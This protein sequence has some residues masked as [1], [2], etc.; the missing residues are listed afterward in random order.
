MAD[1]ASFLSSTSSNAHWQRIGFRRRAGVCVPLF[2]LYSRQ[3]IGIGDLQ[4]LK[5]FVDWCVATGHT[6][7]QL[8]PLN[9][10]GFN[11]RPYDAQSSCALDPIYLS[12]RNLIGVSSPYTQE[13]KTLAQQY[14][15][16][17]GRVNYALKRDKLACCMTMFEH[18]ERHSIRFKQFKGRTAYWLDD[19]ALFTV[20]KSL[21]N[22]KGWF[23]WDDGFKQRTMSVLNEVKTKHSELLEF[24]RWLQWQLYEQCVEVHSY[25]RA[26]GVLLMGDIPFLT[27]RDSADVWAHP[28]YFRLEQ[29]SGATPDFYCAQGQRWGMPPYNWDTIAHDEYT[30]FKQKLQ[31]NEELY[32]MFR[33]DHLFGV[34]RLWSIPIAEPS[35]TVGLN[36]HFEPSDEHAWETHG[37]TILQM[38]LGSTTMLPCGEDL[39]AAP[40]PAARVMEELGIIGLDVQRWLKDRDHYPYRCKSREEFRTLACAVVSVHDSS[41]A[42]ALWE[43]ELDTVAEG[44]FIKACADAGIDAHAL[45]DILFEPGAAIQGRLRWRKEICTTEVLA[46]KVGKN[47]NELY[48]LVSLYKESFG[49]KQQLWEL[50][51]MTG[52]VEEHVSPA[53]IMRMLEFS[54][55]TN[56]IFS[57]QLL[58]DWILIERYKTIKDIG[59]FRINVPGTVND[60]NWSI[61]LPLSL[62]AM[63]NMKINS[64]ILEMNIKAD[65]A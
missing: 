50:F 13:L 58:L 39:G 10:T 40:P 43:Y 31:Y 27:S 23:E 35:E 14:P 19:Y 63:M 55:H 60:S 12:L 62:E 41:N 47:E 26:K 22:E 37:R 20:I 44:F 15:T 33:I 6:I 45:R 54:A 56:A 18:A 38:M 24:Q 8:L 53:L 21:H 11:F 5:L 51:G 48:H 57:V 16:G 7:I 65:R 17:T 42:A 29:Y 36:G 64:I 46:Q 34:F 49:E 52:N 30:Y 28:I 2:S 1:C 4:D 59:N 32:D 3:S 25:A 61:T 9:D